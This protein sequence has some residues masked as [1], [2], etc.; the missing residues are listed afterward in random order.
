MTV[1]TMSIAVSLLLSRD[2]Q[3]TVEYPDAI[4]VIYT[5][6]D[7]SGINQKQIAVFGTVNPQFG[8]D[9][10]Q[11]PENYECGDPDDSIDTDISSDCED[12]VLV[13]ETIAKTIDPEGIHTFGCA[14]CRNVLTPGDN[15]VYTQ[16][17]D[18]SI[19]VFCTDACRQEATES[20][21]DR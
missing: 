13:A 8:A 21:H 12:P 4:H 10:Y 5:R 7:G 15:V 1:D 3:A 20:I 19:D 2:F 17:S 16:N 14:Y 11:L 6:S 18:T 9:I